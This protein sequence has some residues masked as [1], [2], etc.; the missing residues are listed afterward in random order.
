M[1]NGRGDVLNSVVLKKTCFVI[2]MLAAVSSLFGTEAD[3]IGLT[4]LQQV[5]PFL[6][7]TN[8]PVAQVEAPLNSTPPYQ[9]EVNPSTVGQPTNHFTYISD[10]G[11][12]T[13]FPNSVGTESGHADSVGGNFYGTSSGVAPQVA[14]IYNFEA[15]Y[16]YNNIITNPAPPSLSAAIVNQSFIFCQSDGSH[17]ASNVEAEIDTYYDNYA[18]QYGTLF[19]SGAGNGGQVFPSA[20]CY[21]GIG[22]GVSPGSSSYGPTYNGRCKPDIV[23]P[24]SGV[25]SFSTPYVAGSAALLAQAAAAGDGGVNTNAAKD[26]RTIKA[27]LLNGAVKPSDWT[28]SQSSPLDFRYGAGVL[29]VFNSWH[30]LKM[31][32]HSW[33]ETTSNSAGGS[34]PPGSNPGNESS[35]VGWDFNTI[36]NSPSG[37]GS[38]TTYL[39]QVNHY[40]FNLPAGDSYTLTATLIW[41]RQANQ[42]AIN[43]LNLFLYNTA[44]S[45]VVMISTSAV[46]NVEHIFTTNLP[47]GRY[48]LQVSK[49]PTGQISTDETYSLAYE[50]FS[51]R[52]AAVRTNNDLILTWPIAPAGF[53]LVFSTNLAVPGIWTNVNEIASVNTNSSQNIVSIG[54]TATNR[55]FRLQRP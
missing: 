33:I 51:T 24:G 14:H 30:Q 47:A 12:D 31:G 37:H 41:N 46:D 54:I 36:T 1:P 27:L 4:L 17:Y 48:D 5:N 7:G 49:D 39:E 9:F 25:T 2:A 53:R 19:V 26:V 35:L 10:L 40:Y 3:T 38:G 8:V 43:D 55:F 22:V 16:F 21:N 44:S 28:N 23:A 32:Q 34:H 42:T 18:A 45:N 15:D 20:T 6:R 13:N 29:N 52:L 11:S 50:F